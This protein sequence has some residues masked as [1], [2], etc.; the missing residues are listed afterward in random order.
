M[1]K[2]IL[3][4]VLFFFN[5]VYSQNPGI[6][7]IKQLKAGNPL[8]SGFKGAFSIS[9]NGA[10]LYDIPFTVT[11]GVGGMTP[12]ISIS[13]NSSN[14]T[15][16]IGEGW[17]LN[18][19]SIIGRSSNVNYI[20]GFTQPV[21]FNSEDNLQLDGQRLIPLI[22][23]HGINGA[24]YYT[25][26][27]SFKKIS[28][29]NNT[30]DTVDEIQNFKVETKDG[31]EYYYGDI[32]NAM[33]NSMGINNIS[34]SIGN[35]GLNGIVYTKTL[36]ET[37]VPFLWLVTLIK[38]KNNNW[39]YFTYNMQ[40]NYYSPNEILYGGK[41]GSVIGKIKFTYEWRN[42]K[43]TG[44]SNP[45]NWEN[46]KFIRG[47]KIIINKPL[48]KITSS[49]IE[50]GSGKVRTVK[51]YNFDYSLDTN[52]NKLELLKVYQSTVG[53]LDKNNTTTYSKP[54]KDDVNS[55]MFNWNKTNN[56]A[57]FSD[58]LTTNENIKLEEDYKFA[59]ADFNGDG[60]P[61][62]L[63]HKN[64]GDKIVL[65]LSTNDKKGKF[66]STN[67][68]D[69][70]KT[71][72]PENAK[73]FTGDYNS[74][75]ANDLLYMANENDKLNIYI[76][77]SEL[78]Q[79]GE[80]LSF[81]EKIFK[82]LCDL[83][84]IE[85]KKIFY[86][87]GDLN[88]DGFS[89][90]LIYYLNNNL[91]NYQSLI[92][93]KDSIKVGLI[94]TQS[95]GDIPNENFISQITDINGDG[96]TDML[97]TWTTDKGWFVKSY[98]FQNSKD[99]NVSIMDNETKT[100][101][102]SS[103]INS[104]LIKL[105]NGYTY[106]E[107]I[108]KLQSGELTQT[109]LDA[110]INKGTQQT[111]VEGDYSRL[112]NIMYSDINK[113]GNIDLIISNTDDSGWAY[114]YAL[115]KGNGNFEFQK[116]H[117][118]S[119][120]IKFTYNCKSSF[121]DFN[122][123]GNLDI[124]IQTTNS[125]GWHQLIG[126]GNGKG[127]F[128]L[129]KPDSKLETLIAKDFSYSQRYITD[130]VMPYCQSRMYSLKR[131]FDDGRIKKVDDCNLNDHECFMNNIRLIFPVETGF[132]PNREKRP[133]QSTMQDPLKNF[134]PQ[135]LNFENNIKRIID[136]SYVNDSI[137][138]TPQ[139]AFFCGGE[140][141]KYYTKLTYGDYW[142][143]YVVDLNGDGISD[144]LLT[145][146]IQI[147]NDIALNLS[148]NELEDG[149]FT[150]SVLSLESKKGYLNE[151][152]HSNKS[153]I[154][155]EYASVLND[156]I[157][158]FQRTPTVYPIVRCNAPIYTVYKVGTTNGINL[159]SINWTQYNYYNGIVSLSGKGF[160]GFENSRV[161]NLQNNN[162]T[163][164]SYWLE[165]DFLKYGVLP[166]KSI[167]TY[168][169]SYQ[170]P[171]GEEYFNYTVEDKLISNIFNIYNT[172]KTSISNDITGVQTNYSETENKF[173]LWGNLSEMKN[174]RGLGIDEITQIIKNTYFEVIDNEWIDKWLLGRLMETEI[175]T[176]R[177]G[178][179]TTRKSAF[180]YNKINGQLIK[181]ISDIQDT[182][183][184][185]SLTKEYVLNKY[186]NIEK[187]I[188]FPTYNPKPELTKTTITTYTKDN[189]FVEK[190]TDPSGYITT[191]IIDPLEGLKIISN[192]SDENK[193]VIT[194]DE[195][196]RF[197]KVVSQDGLESR[198]ELRIC[199]TCEFKDKATYFSIE[200]N[201]T[202]DFNIPSV[203]Y[204]DN[205]GK[206][207]RKINYD[208][209]Y[210][211]IITEYE[212]DSFGN[213]I[214]ESL[215]YFDSGKI[216]NTVNQYDKLNRKIETVL[217]DGSTIKSEYLGLSGIVTNEKGQ[218]STSI[219]NILGE[220]VQSIDDNGYVV[221][222]T[223]DAF[224]R[225]STITDKSN[226][227][228]KMEYD[229]NGN[230]ILY[231]NPNFK[232]PEIS[233]Y[234]VY[235]RKI[236]S[237]DPNEYSKTFEYDKSDRITK[238]F[239]KREGY[240]HLFEYT[241][242][243]PNDNEKGK[244]KLKNIKSDSDD[245]PFNES[246]IYDAVGQ[247]ITHTYTV[248]PN[249]W[250]YEP[251]TALKAKNKFVYQ[252]NYSNGQVTN[253]IY[254][255]SG[256]QNDK[257]KFILNYEYTNGTLVKVFGKGN[258]K[259]IDFWELNETNSLGTTISSKLGDSVLMNQEFD[260][261]INNLLKIEYTNP[262]KTIAGIK[263]D[264]DKL[265]NL[266]F[267]QDIV[268]SRLLDSIYYDNLNRVIEVKTNNNYST[269][270]SYYENGDVKEKQFDEEY[271]M[272]FTYQKGSNK[273]KTIQLINPINNKLIR[274]QN[275]DYDNYGNM[276]D[277]NFP[278]LFSGK[279]INI[280]YNQF[281]LPFSVGSINFNY[282]YDGTKC[283]I[284]DYD[285][286]FGETFLGNLS[287]FGYQF[288]KHDKNGV[289]QF[290]KIN[291]LVNGKVI[292]NYYTNNGKVDILLKDAHNNV[293]SITDS[294]GE[295][296]KNFAYDIWGLKRN[297]SLWTYEWNKL[298]IIPNDPKSKGF[299]HNI[300]LDNYGLVDMSA[301]L[302]DP[303]AG[304]FIN[305][306]SV[307]SNSLSN[308]QFF[309]SYLYCYNNPTVFS[310]GNG[311]F[312]WVVLAVAMY[313]GASATGGSLLPWQW[314]DDWWKGAL[315]GGI[316]V[317][318]GY[319]AAP[320]LFTG[321]A[322]TPGLVFAS[323]AA[324]GFAGGFTSTLVN[325]GNFSQAFES[326]L[327]GGIV[328]GVTA[329]FTFG[330]GES[331]GNNPSAFSGNY[332]AKA[333]LHGVNQGI[334]SEMMD[335]SFEHGFLAGSF[336]S[337]ATP[338]S[339]IPG[340]TGEQRIVISAMV[341]G[342]SS[343]LGG[344]KF[345]NGAISGAMVQIYNENQSH[346][347]KT[348]KNDYKIC[349]SDESICIEGGVQYGNWLNV[350]NDGEV[351][352]SFYDGVGGG[353]SYGKDGTTLSGGFGW[354]TKIGGKGIPALPSANI[355]LNVGSRNGFFSSGSL[356]G[357]SAQANLNLNFNNIINTMNRNYIE[358]NRQFENY[359]MRGTGY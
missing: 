34:T 223:Y 316:S 180:E 306:D 296:L 115:G 145:Y 159:N 303:I 286:N 229:I 214:R 323:G 240:N 301:R 162:Y 346:D 149:L 179:S 107:V 133:Y 202:S 256:V 102:P 26:N 249:N 50:S 112:G 325:G 259:S 70:I 280:V 75:G 126:F 64:Y 342:T 331:F 21:I 279:N 68:Q 23:N 164:K 319:F 158:P 255:S 340:T 189:R 337:A 92:F 65:I 322:A 182:T 118:I 294:K 122:G 251:N 29:A 103:T 295:N 200:T 196:G 166:L 311:K 66:I 335:G 351:G 55:I 354:E 85:S 273:Y 186:G 98:L 47:E 119:D 76:Y 307:T 130:N 38:D 154:K 253:I 161:I 95:Q 45:W 160:L 278:Y 20:D 83:P 233:L 39:I 213:L 330:I 84:K 349:S 261:K 329:C 234:D 314:S 344:G 293:I 203:S 266:I 195:F 328:G 88:A 144:L 274:S 140:E 309:N 6:E 221:N 276:L 333:S 105:P 54:M 336:T 155:L 146:P 227:T 291:I 264:Y 139:D 312:P 197:Q 270:V 69:T 131:I 173:D 350:S 219:K 7:Y 343:S 80:F 11:P 127:L 242:I 183:N 288:D 231:S 120:K 292:A 281:N 113:D 94:K 71:K 220:L 14:S 211:K 204:Y 206:I 42:R 114:Y 104:T 358:F 129:T 318:G 16:I 277:A 236:E 2:K 237:K 153:K 352:F 181:E 72:I 121:G 147:P 257:S 265:G 8:Y 224:N 37:N 90:I 245:H 284:Y 246:F 193:T 263:Y 285:S 123:D 96:I 215:P 298:K 217:P 304:R 167:Q 32:D 59:I 30:G 185:L 150:F 248:K 43:L 51:E 148:K 258:N 308:T 332:F 135:N 62:K 17:S 57:K 61:D 136:C 172:R 178:K 46:T 142:Q 18:G 209:K 302:Y 10:A 239:A 165:K 125:S 300:S 287:E 192:F 356:F 22:E 210:R 109:E 28:I 157:I 152:I 169:S 201:S 53:H 326:G 151:I 353:I 244:G 207:I 176:S 12:Q 216:N 299:L 313:L 132:F 67:I 171:V 77:Y 58:A 252:Y 156:S 348:N 143:P 199:N 3:I 52:S 262:L 205:T 275:V 97:Y 357:V 124:I 238:E 297:A 73:V 290:Q 100:I 33:L 269:K 89:D 9:E 4:I 134:I 60:F 320:A 283:G 49:F 338:I 191:K 305:V 170:K 334:A 347:S 310:D 48:E 79:N 267:K 106:D 93:Y 40:D 355:G 25:E 168:I 327:K 138:K 91:L 198:T 116:K 108:Q 324:A 228:Y 268:N 31:L 137:V 86:G 339:Q 282:S 78:N 241:Y 226:L 289:L 194:P 141:Y 15:S 99:L 56:T 321:G 111:I 222:Y 175:T 82:D 184:N 41:D 117:P 341:G 315:V 247:L 225:I 271:L 174:K 230:R 345:A 13:Y 254:P 63:T 35:K 87:L 250:I 188:V 272:D 260:S 163:D 128:S 27:N 177:L 101:I 1:K 235:G 359:I 110:L 44:Q 74:D 81:K 208:F 212:Y 5:V 24:L 19:F 36:G 243:M 232:K 317:A 190:T 187:S 218:K